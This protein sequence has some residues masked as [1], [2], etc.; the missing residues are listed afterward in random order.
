[1]EFITKGRSEMPRQ[2]TEPTREM[3]EDKDGE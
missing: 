3:V 2:S 1:V